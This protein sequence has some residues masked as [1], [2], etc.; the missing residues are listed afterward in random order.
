VASD[1]RRLR[2]SELCRLLNSTPLGEVISEGQLKRHRTRAGLR[3]GDERHVDLLRYVAWLVQA[4]HAPKAEPAGAALAAQELEEAA[5]GAAAIATKRSETQHSEQELTGK[6]ESLIAALLTEPTHEAA[7]AK[8]GI[9]RVTVYCWMQLDAFRAAYRR[10][11]R[12]L[13]EAAI[14]RIQASTGQA[15]DTL[16]AVARQ[17]RRDSDRVRAAVALLNHACRGLEDTDVLHGAPEAGDSSPMDTGDVV[18]MLAGR[19]R[20]VASAELPTAEKA[21]LTAALSDALLRAIGVNVLD[22][23]LEALQ[24]VLL[25]RK[26][27]R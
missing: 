18:Q 7:A 19:L 1:P 27:K 14:G 10:A 8:A 16:V 9:N 15:V 26:D 3:I 17:G 11:R 6:Q 21:R 22:Q 20:E 23:R 12:E 4:R 2:P 5:Q 25:G 13:V 24:G